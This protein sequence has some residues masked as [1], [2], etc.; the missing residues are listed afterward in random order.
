MSSR[1]VPKNRALKKLLGVRLTG[2]KN[3]AWASVPRGWYVMQ[4]GDRATEWRESCFGRSSKFVV[5]TV[6]EIF[7]LDGRRNLSF[8]PTSKIWTLEFFL[9]GRQKNSF[10]RSRTN[11][12]IMCKEV[13]QSADDG[14]SIDSD[15]SRFCRKKY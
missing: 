12:W 1:R 9:D 10:G 7:C 15:L 8:G 2:T 5:W 4:D 6:G 13:T 14:L 11:R 3:T